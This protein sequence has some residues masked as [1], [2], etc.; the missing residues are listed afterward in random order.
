MDLSTRFSNV[1]T[2]ETEFRAVMGETS[3]RAARKEIE[4]L[5]EHCQAF[6]ARSPFVLVTFRPAVTR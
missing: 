1:I 2:S 3:V 4:F 5:N 6:I